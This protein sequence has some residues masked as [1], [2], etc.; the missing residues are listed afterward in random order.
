MVISFVLLFFC[1]FVVVVVVVVTIRLCTSAQ[2]DEE[3]WLMK[4]WDVE[5]WL[6]KDEWEVWL[7]RDLVR[8][9]QRTVLALQYYSS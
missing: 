4:D 9:P 7:V 1:F 8:V 5:V 2:L 3:V 6:M